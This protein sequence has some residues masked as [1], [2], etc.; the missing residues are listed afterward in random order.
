MYDKSLEVVLGHEPWRQRA[1]HPEAVDDP[2]WD[3]DDT[4]L[5]EGTVEWE[6][7]D[8]KYWVC[9]TCGYIGW[10]TQQAHRAPQ[11]PQEMLSKSRAFFLEERSKISPCEYAAEPQQL[12]QQADFVAAAALRAA[13]MKSPTELRAFV[14][15][16]SRL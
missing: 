11:H 16:L 9:T 14:E 15:K 7:S 13:A 5:C 12:E 6:G 8:S 2:L 1:G 3:P 4:A 10:C